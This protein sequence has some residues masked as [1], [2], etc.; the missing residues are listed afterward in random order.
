ML[1]EHWRQTELW[2]PEGDEAALPL[3]L[4]ELGM[5][6]PVD[7]R[8]ELGS[9]ADSAPLRADAP[10]LRDQEE[11]RQ[12]NNPEDQYSEG[13]ASGGS[14]EKKPQNPAANATL[15]IAEHQAAEC[16]GRHTH[17]GGTGTPSLICLPHG[18]LSMYVTFTGAGR[19]ALDHALALTGNPCCAPSASGIAG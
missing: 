10:K 17:H 12:P 18:F 15:L 6:A 14:A 9:Y 2:D 16:T 11:Q 5:L 3:A 4:A 19:D 1:C 8:R 7:L 13:D